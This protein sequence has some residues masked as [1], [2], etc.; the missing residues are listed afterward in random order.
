MFLD[1][2][3]RMGGLR[4]RLRGLLGVYFVNFYSYVFSTPH[5]SSLAVDGVEP[6]KKIGV[7]NSPQRIYC[8]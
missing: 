2:V 1:L 3:P 4:E 6:K 8:G 7:G 5:I